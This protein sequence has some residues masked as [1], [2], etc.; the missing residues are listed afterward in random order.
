MLNAIAI[1]RAIVIVVRVAPS[2]KLSAI[3]SKKQVVV[4]VWHL[5]FASAFPSREVSAAEIAEWTGGDESFVRDKVGIQSRRYLAK[6][7]TPL[8]LAKAAADKG[9]KKAG[10]NAR[11]LDWL[12]F[13]TQNPDFRLPQSSALLAD[14]IGAKSEVAAFDIGLGCSGWVYAVT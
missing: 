2:S 4:V 3:K 5:D 9:L 14:A 10:L 8:D 6:D 1:A 13:V 7:E 12:V 11:D